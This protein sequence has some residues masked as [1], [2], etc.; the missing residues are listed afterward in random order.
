MKTADIVCICR[1]QCFQHIPLDLKLPAFRRILRWAE[2]GI[3]YASIASSFDR[4]F[5]Q[6]R[7][8]AFKNLLDRIDR[9]VRGLGVVFKPPCWDIDLM[10]ALFCEQSDPNDAHSVL[11]TLHDFCWQHRNS[12][13]SRS[14]W[15]IGT[16]LLSNAKTAEDTQAA[17]VFLRAH[18]TTTI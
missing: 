18:I 2:R 6:N 1:F 9:H 17:L 13:E 7:W 4:V 15:A 8:C 12:P 16:H 3:V 10:L 5:K 11:Q 14:P